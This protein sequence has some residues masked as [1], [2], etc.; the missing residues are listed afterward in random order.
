MGCSTWDGNHKYLM[1]RAWTQSHQRLNA[2]IYSI[3][4]LT[5]VFSKRVASLRSNIVIGYW[6]KQ[7]EGLAQET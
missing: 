1:T 3:R 5:A 2:K 7:R 4:K 6:L